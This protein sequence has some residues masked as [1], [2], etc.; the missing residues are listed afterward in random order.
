MV[1]PSAT[2]TERWAKP[3]EWNI[4]T[5]ITVVSRARNGTF[6]NR[7]TTAPLELVGWR[8]APFGV[9]V[10]PL[11]SITIVEA[12]GGVGGS[13]VL[14]SAISSSSVGSLGVMPSS[15]HARI[16]SRPAVAPATSSANS[17]S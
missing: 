13:L 15:T 17:L 4:G 2:A 14:P 11:V 6:E 10:V 5:A 1:E 8:G 7:A 9:P 12:S 16:A 3:R